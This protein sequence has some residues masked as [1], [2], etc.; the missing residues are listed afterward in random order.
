MKLAGRRQSTNV[1]D[2]RRNRVRA[3]SVEKQAVLDAVGSANAAKHDAKTLAKGTP[4][5]GKKAGAD[6]I[7]KALAKEKVKA[8][9]S[10]LN[11]KISSQNKNRTRGVQKT[12]SRGQNLSRV[13]KQ[14]ERLTQ[15]R[16]K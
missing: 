15:G 5:M 11:R 1:D 2:R 7:G 13:K 3:P 8:E 16:K 14:L 4:E 10:R 9:K 12:E 6:A